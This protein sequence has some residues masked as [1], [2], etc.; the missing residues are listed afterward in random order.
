MLA[1][2]P[3]HSQHLPEDLRM[4]DGSSL[5]SHLSVVCSIVRLTAGS[6]TEAQLELCV[7][8]MAE[9]VLQMVE[10]VEVVRTLGLTPYPGAVW[11][12]MGTALGQAA[13]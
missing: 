8:C 3:I 2:V 1:T 10:R 13:L 9:L 12:V 11:P 4:L 7:R 5:V 6:C